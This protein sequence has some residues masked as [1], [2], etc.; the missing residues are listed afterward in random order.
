[1]GAGSE[2]SAGGALVAKVVFLA[3]G[4]WWGVGVQLMVYAG[5]ASDPSALLP[6][7]TWYASMLLGLLLSERFLKVRCCDGGGA[8]PRGCSV[9]IGC[10]SD[11]RTRDASSWSWWRLPPLRGLWASSDLVL[12]SWC[13]Y[14]GTVA[15][16]MGLTLA[17]SGIFGLIYSSVSCWAALFAYCLLGRRLVAM[18]VVGMLI[19]VAGLIVASLDNEIESE[20]GKRVAIGSALIGFWIVWPFETLKNQAQAGMKGSALELMRNMGGVR[21]TRRW[22]RTAASFGTELELTAPRDLLPTT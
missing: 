1:M 8:E 6:N 12:A 13:D 19:V 5:I 14:L 21:G 9:A 20:D 4:V 18:Q 15:T 2:L 22:P 3:T 16:A 10:L 17:G 11:E 7:F